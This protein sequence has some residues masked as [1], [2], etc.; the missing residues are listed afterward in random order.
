MEIE[1][2]EVSSKPKISIPVRWAIVEEKNKGCSGSQVYD[3]FGIPSSTCNSIYRKWKE[4]GDIVDLPR[5]G[6]PRKINEKEEKNLLKQF[7]PTQIIV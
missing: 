2:Q 7:R 5:S 6:R 3:K 1:D 4:T